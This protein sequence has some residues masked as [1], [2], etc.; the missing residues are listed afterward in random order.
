MSTE[1]APP[2]HSATSS[3]VPAAPASSADRFMRKLLR[4][5]EGKTATAEEARSAFQKSIFISAARCILMYVFFPF[6]L[7]LIGVAK[8]VGPV[9]GLVIG[10]LAIVS[11]VFSVRRFWRANHSKRW[12]YTVFGVVIIGFLIVLAVEDLTSITS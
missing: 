2:S 11:I 12:H 7:P 6:V 10:T 1:I 8:G 4:L 5:P 9:I 3:T